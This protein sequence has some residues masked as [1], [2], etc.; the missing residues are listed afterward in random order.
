VFDILHKYEGAAAKSETLL[1]GTPDFW[2]GAEAIGWLETYENC[3]KVSIDSIPEKFST[4]T[5]R[6]SSLFASCYLETS[7]DPPTPKDMVIRFS[8]SSRI[9]REILVHILRPLLGDIFSLNVVYTVFG[10]FGTRYDTDYVLRCFGEWFMTLSK[11]EI[12]QGM[13]S[14]NPPMTRFLR[15]LATRT[16]E[17]WDDASPTTVLAPLQACC[18]SSSDL[19]RSFLLAAICREAAAKASSNI[20]KTSYGKVLSRK[21][22]EDWD[23]ILRQLRVCLLVSLRLGGSFCAPLSI[24]L[25][26]E[27]EVF[28]VY[29]WIARDELVMSHDQEEISLLEQACAISSHSFDPSQPESDNPARLRALQN[30]CLASKITDN[31]RVEYFLDFDDEDRFGA[32]L[33]FLKSHNNP[34]LLAAHRSILLSLE[35]VKEPTNLNHLHNSYMA[36]KSITGDDYNLLVA[37]LSLEIWQRCAVVFRAQ[38]FGWEDNQEIGEDNLSSLLQNKDWFVPFGRIALKFLRVLRSI[39]FDIASALTFATPTE[40]KTATWP[41]VRPDVSLSRVVRRLFA[42]DKSALDTHCVVICALLVSSNVTA[43]VKCVPSIYDCFLPTSFSKPFA[44]DPDVSHLRAAF[45]ED[46]IVT[47]ANVWPNVVVEQFNLQEIETLAHVWLIDPKSVRSQFL[48]AMYELEKDNCVDDLLTRNV[49]QIDS[50]LFVEHGVDIACRRLN[51]YL[52]GK[53]MSA[54]DRRNVMG[55]LDADLCEWIE[56]RANEGR[57]LV[58]GLPPSR[59]HISG[60]NVL[61]MRLLSM[62]TSSNVDPSLRANINSIMLLCNLLVKEIGC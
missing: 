17:S 37:A 12:M 29:E 49:S 32:L 31:E 28:S 41:Q 9:R 40:N 30:S 5:L 21:V 47:R 18:R 15:D 33:L 58:N 27:G 10:I 55:V 34:A 13:L 48:L 59:I 8:E 42:V 23:K 61:I 2:W 25:V 53:R 43:L 7:M 36:L 62:S 22:I 19:V 6:I 50:R 35:W 60:T 39:D 51:E 11:K 24:E 1:T 3:S 56:T 20:E 4:G 45:V 38:L 46:A 26:D 14:P 54:T 57:W 44:S 52:S 16:L